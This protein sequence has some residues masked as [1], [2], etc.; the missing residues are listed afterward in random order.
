VYR[1]T[2]GLGLFGGLKKLK[3]FL[4]LFVAAFLF[5]ST[6]SGA[7][8]EQDVCEQLCEEALDDCLDDA[9][10]SQWI[11]V[12]YCYN[13]RDQGWSTDLHTDYCVSHCDLMYEYYRLSCYLESDYCLCA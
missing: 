12:V 4:L 6:P 1:F 9:D 5:Q 11:C 13:N 3:V 10:Y 2:C 7:Q 8:S